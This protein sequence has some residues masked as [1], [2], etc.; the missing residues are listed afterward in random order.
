MADLSPFHPNAEPPR[1]ADEMAEMERLVRVDQLMAT[2]RSFA[3][4]LPVNMLLSVACALV[5]WFSGQHLEAA[6]WLAASCLVNAGRGLLH[7]S[8]GA[9]LRAAEGAPIPRAEIDRHL[10]L[11]W[12]VTGV[13]GL[14]W[15]LMPALCALYTTPQSLFFLVVGCGI[16]AGAISH[17]AAYARVPISFITPQLLSAAAAMA[18]VGGFDRQ[19]LA[20]TVLLYLAALVVTGRRAEVAF[21]TACRLTHQVNGMNASLKIANERALTLAGDMRYRADHDQLTGL[22]NRGGFLRKAAAHLN[23]R[24]DPSCLMLLD[25]DGFKA[26][27]DAFGHQVGDEILVEVADRLRGA[28]PGEVLISRWGGDEFAIVCATGLAEE[29]AAA[30]ADRLIGAITAPYIAFGAVARVGLSVGIHLSEEIDMPERLSCADLALYA[31]KTGGRN[32]YHLFDDAL[33]TQLDVRCDIERDLPTALGDG[34]IQMW[35]QP[36]FCSASNRICGLEALVRWHHAIHGWISP[37]DLMAIAAQAGF[38][39]PLM[40]LILDRV[41]AMIAALRARNLDDIS[42]AMNVSPREMS[43]LPVDEL[44]LA[45]LDAWQL[46]PSALEIEITEETALDIAHTT[47]KLAL[48][49]RA[50]I[51]ISIDDFGVGYSSLSSLRTLHV[52]RI[53]IDRCFVSGLA[54]SEGDQEVVKAVLNLGQSLRIEVIAEGV[55][56]EDDL[57]TLRAFGCQFMQGY[58]LGRPLAAD[59]CLAFVTTA[60]RFEAFAILPQLLAG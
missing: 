27:N 28:L 8:I 47:R 1:R 21:R 5:A 33:R 26:I 24:S 50:G 30:L 41:C 23:R 15:A 7:R 3:V 52:D 12:K 31:A 16:T 10:A 34:S 53:K 48:L 11:L 57:R 56:N 22:L 45:A 20:A 39:R 35:F 44:I 13:S 42:V 4:A 2:R 19:T 49:S 60:P 46:P 25:L 51:R 38:A 55:E 40:D 9:R 36:I 17:G 43:Q 6:L 32:R 59:Q 29:S 58:H 54:Q 37:A 18:F 14:V